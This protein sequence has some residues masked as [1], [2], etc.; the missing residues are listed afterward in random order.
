MSHDIFSL[1]TVTGDCSVKEIERFFVNIHFQF[2]KHFSKKEIRL[3]VN[4]S[5]TTLRNEAIEFF[6]GFFLQIFTSRR[7][8]FVALF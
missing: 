2:K 7:M 5:I 6:G 8:D 3:S 1:F 4:R